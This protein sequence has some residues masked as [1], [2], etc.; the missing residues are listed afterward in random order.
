MAR[1]KKKK[2][3]QNQAPGGKGEQPFN[4]PFA[5]FKKELKAKAAEPKQKNRRSQSSG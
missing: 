2:S 5:A 1:R 4:N 3:G